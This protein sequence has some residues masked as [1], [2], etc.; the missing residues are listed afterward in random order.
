MYL[1][2]KMFIAIKK[3]AVFLFVAIYFYI[4]FE[5]YSNSA[6]GSD[7]ANM[8]LEAKDIID[9]NIFLSDWNLTGLTFITTD[10]LYYIVAV[11]LFGVDKLS[12]AFAS[13]LMYVVMILLGMQFFRDKDSCFKWKAM[14]Y[15]A[16]AGFPCA[17][18]MGCARVHTGCI[19]WCFISLLCIVQIK[20]VSF[21][22]KYY[23]YC[24]G[25]I[26]ALTLAC[27]GDEI[28][29]LALVLPIV[30]VA[31]IHICRDY[32]NAKKCNKCDVIILLIGC[33]SAL[34]GKFIDKLYFIIGGANKNAYMGNKIFVPFDEYGKKISIYIE[35]LFSL[36]DSVFKGKEVV[37]VNTVFYFF[38][39]VFIFVVFCFLGNQIIRFIKGKEYD[40]ITLI[41]GSGFVIISLVLI[42]TDM[43]SDIGEARYMAYAPCIFSIIF[44]KNLSLLKVHTVRDITNEKKVLLLILAVVSVLLMCR[45]AIPGVAVQRQTDVRN[46]QIA[47]VLEENDLE[48]GYGNFWDASATTV[49]GG[50]NVSVRAIIVNEQGAFIYRWFCK[51][52]WYSELA[53][54]VILSNDILDSN[55]R[56]AFGEPY[57]V[58]TE[59][60]ISIYI[61]DYDISTKLK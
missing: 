54:F 6:M 41:L 52:S 37:S 16:I 25:A 44:L 12:Y 2:S 46:I 14:F 7:M 15:L 1:S 50:D 17:A 35:A 49:Y 45:I 9:G 55:V 61:F 4:I 59:D 28:P 39:V 18:L 11:L 43:G 3:I 10:L 38:I 31:A 34:L 56:N 47:E 20:K 57:R 32:V 40:Y 19:V 33:C 23:L 26:I 53:N 5:M 22:K 58:I 29:L 42:V 36:F 51:E 13:A 30:L 24:G 21:G 60:D 27:A 48:N 8:I